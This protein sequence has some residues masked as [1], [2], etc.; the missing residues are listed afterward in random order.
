MRRFAPSPI[1]FFVI[2]LSIGAGAESVRAQQSNYF[3][4]SF[5]DSNAAPMTVGQIPQTQAHG[6]NDSGTVVGMYGASSDTF[7]AFEWAN[8]HFLAGNF[9]FPDASCSFA[10]GSELNGINDSGEAVGDYTDVNGFTHAYYILKGVPVSYDAPGST[11]TMATAVN[12]V[13]VIV[14]IY[15][16]S[17]QHGFE[18]D[19]THFTSFDVPGCRVPQIQGVDDK[20]DVVGYC[21]GQT[22]PGFEFTPALGA[23]V[24]IGPSGAE[25]ARPTGIN[26]EGQIVGTY[27]AADTSFHGFVFTGGTYVPFDPQGSTFTECGGVNSAGQFVGDYTNGQN[28]DHGFLASGPL[29]LD[30][31]SSGSFPGL[32]DGPVTANINILPSL[33]LGA[34]RPVDGVAADGVTEV[35]VRIPA[36]NVGD[37]FTL[38]LLNDQ[39]GQSTDTNADGVLGNPGDATL[40]KSQITVSAI[41]VTTDSNTG[42]QV[43]FAFAVY[44]APMDFARQK[45]DGSYEKG[46][47]SFNS[48]NAGFGVASS[49]TK[50]LLGFQPSFPD[51]TLSCRSVFIRIQNLM[52][53]ASSTAPVVVLRPPVVMIHGLWSDWTSWNSFEP[54]VKDASTVDGRFYVG[55]VSYDNLVGPSI[56]SSD[57]SYL[58]LLLQRARANSLGF[59]FNAPNV[60]A[61]TDGW[62]ENFK[63]GENP[64][65]IPAAA[66]QADLVAHSMGG[67]IARTMVLQPGFQSDNTFGQG[68]IH[69][70]ITIDTPHLGSPVAS[71]L[72]SPQEDGVCVQ[73]VLALDGKFTFNAVLFGGGITDGAIADLALSSP[74]L[75]SIANQNQHPVP[76]AM[77]AGIYT[78]FSSFFPTLISAL[79]QP[80]GADPLAL[81]LSATRWPTVFFNNGPNDV[82]VSEASQLNGLEGI[83]FSGYSHSPGARSIGF[84]GP[85]VLDAGDQVIPNAVIT[86]LNTP[87]TQAIFNLLNP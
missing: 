78:N 64:L 37:Q 82:I 70:L 40:S 24:P 5:V 51:D 54:L 35:V 62:I 12:N 55:R 77:I 13:G 85:T 49:T 47:C 61:Q 15:N 4:N 50:D 86:L 16:D 69:K 33:G 83:T 23:L 6:V 57:P 63:Q 43:P 8:G 9:D 65:G 45:A 56:V 84:P 25:Q 72:I 42:Q 7:H 75:L 73:P 59:A 81:D 18:Y 14:G 58:G 66:V 11:F 17:A 53:G 34:A 52:N 1:Y 22:G 87:V 38:T 20:G 36:N 29:L 46:I 41:N 48:H 21:L 39:N 60:L 67:D 32:M 26:N 76:T 10:C 74:A 79:C 2:F 28:V 80:S 68:T 19:G 3:V 31:V 30:P 44:R 27:I 71:Q